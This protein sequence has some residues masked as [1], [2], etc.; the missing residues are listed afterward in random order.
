MLNPDLRLA[1]GEQS[2]RPSDDGTADFDG[3]DTAVASVGPCGKICVGRPGRGV[4]DHLH[5]RRRLRSLEARTERF[6]Q[7]CQMPGRRPRDLR[8]DFTSL[9]AMRQ[10]LRGLWRRKWQRYTGGQK[11]E[12]QLFRTVT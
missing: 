7:G 11:K 5:C 12:T 2:F 6:L 9:S 4:T 1:T 8:P 3:G 10:G